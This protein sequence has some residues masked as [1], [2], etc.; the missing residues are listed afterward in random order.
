MIRLRDEVTENN[1]KDIKKARREKK[2]TQR[3]ARAIWL[4][5]LAWCLAIGL[6][7]GYMF[8]KAW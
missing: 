5:E 6:W 4:L 2:Q 1:W 3:Q 8:G 7:L